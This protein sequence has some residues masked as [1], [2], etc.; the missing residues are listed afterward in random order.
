MDNYSQNNFTDFME[1]YCKHS[2]IDKY[3]L[4]YDIPEDQIDSVLYYAFTNNYLSSFYDV[5]VVYYIIKSFK[6]ISEN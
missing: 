6:Y 5:L 3:M 4:T 1:L 2:S